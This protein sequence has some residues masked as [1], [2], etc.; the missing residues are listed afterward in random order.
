MLLSMTLDA[1]TVR[2]IADLTNTDRRSVRA[3]AVGK[4]VRGRAG[5]RIRT[6]LRTLGIEMPVVAEISEKEAA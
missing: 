5:E 4:Y 6:A 3:V 1:A 2:K